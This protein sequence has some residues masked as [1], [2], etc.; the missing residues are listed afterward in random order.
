MPTGGVGSGAVGLVLDSG[1]DDACGVE[2]EG[3]KLSGAGRQP[4]SS[5]AAA[6]TSTPTPRFMV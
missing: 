6:M 5:T 1:V 3:A 4:A 2:A